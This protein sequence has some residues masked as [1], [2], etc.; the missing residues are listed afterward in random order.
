MSD[1]LFDLYMER[2]AA[3]RGVALAPGHGF[4]FTELAE[5]IGAKGNEQLRSLKKVMNREVRIGRVDRNE[6]GVYSLAPD[7][8]DP[9]VSLAL[10]DL[11]S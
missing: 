10:R 11:Y 8:L 5:R 4:T 2:V 9:D 7:G 1:S 6:A 3:E